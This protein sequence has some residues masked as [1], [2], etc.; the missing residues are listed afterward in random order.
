[1]ML[2]NLI[3][4]AILA[5]HASY[6]WETANDPS[7]KLFIKDL[8]LADSIAPFATN[9]Q[10]KVKELEL[11]LTTALNELDGIFEQQSAT[12]WHDYIS[13]YQA[14]YLHPSLQND[15]SIESFNYSMFDDASWLRDIEKEAAIIDSWQ[16]EAEK[17]TNIAIEA[18]RNLKKNTTDVRDGTRLDTLNRL[19]AN[20]SD[21]YDRRGNAYNH[22][23][24]TSETSPL[25]LSE[26]WRSA[27]FEVESQ[28]D[29]NIALAT[30]RTLPL[31]RF[32][33]KD[34][35]LQ[36]MV[37][38]RATRRTRY[39]VGP[40]NNDD[41]SGTLDSSSIF[42]FNVGAVA[43]LARI[44]EG[45]TSKLMSTS[46]F[47]HH[48]SSMDKKIS[49]LKAITNDSDEFKTPAQ[50]A[51]E[52][53]ALET[54]VALKRVTYL[55]H[56]L[57]QSTKINL[58]RARLASRLKS[59]AANDYSSEKMTRIERGVVADREMKAENANV[60][61]ETLLVYFNAI[62]EIRQ[63]WNSTMRQDISRKFDAQ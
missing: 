39:H 12:D 26:T 31:M 34:D 38:S 41:N 54:E 60:G 59:L 50:M 15:Y 63:K 8:E 16:I 13:K 28:V 45:I 22:R 42:S 32:K 25:H 61:M 1:M 37:L 44:M 52:V 19:M 35:K 51:S 10:S 5:K 47:L 46:S 6:P 43:Q 58:V 14:E 62:E 29:P 18:F 11:N 36:E 9:I 17:L 4:A 7:L 30:I 23:I 2:S 27:G 48:H 49:Q 33:L 53:A 57:V 55:C 3:Q 20:A 21:I 24:L 40:V 56:A